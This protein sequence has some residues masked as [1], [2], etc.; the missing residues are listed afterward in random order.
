MP[1]GPTRSDRTALAVATQVRAMGCERFE[2]GLRDP[3]QGTMI[4]RTWSVP[5]FEPGLGWLKWQNAIGHDIYIRPAG[6]VGLLLL[7]DLTADGLVQMKHDGLAPAVIVETS[8]RNFQGWVRVSLEPI[9]PDLATAAARILAERYGADINS[10]DWRHFGRLA[11][12]TNPKPQHRRPSGLSPYVL[13]HEA[14]G[15]IA[16]QGPQILAEAIHRLRTHPVQPAQPVQHPLSPG[17]VGLLTPGEVYRQ[18]AER[19][20]ARYPAPDWSRIDW[21]VLKDIASNNRAIDAQY[22]E[23]ALREG[24]PDLGDTRK[25]GHVD[26]YIRRTVQKV[27]SDPDVIHARQRLMPGE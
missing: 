7:D 6:S 10:A 26:D 23:Q 15:A 8:P 5:E 24:S 9:P 1:T 2:I 25:R 11:G 22:L 16:E 27:M 4:S 12:F 13:I 20:L 3:I 19:L 21:M 18:Y 17:P 14:R